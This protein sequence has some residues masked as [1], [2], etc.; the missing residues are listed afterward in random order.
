VGFACLTALDRLAG[1][2]I[3]AHAA[4]RPD[5]AGSSP[6]AV[7]FRGE[8]HDVDLGRPLGHEPGFE[9]PAVILSADAVNNG[10]R[11]IVL[12]VPIGTTGYG[13]RSHVELE[14]GTSGLTR[15]SY[16]RCDQ[17]RVVST[18]R[19]LRRRGVLTLDELT[20]VEQAVRFI[21]DL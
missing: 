2:P 18:E 16:A 20:S 15:T 3:E 5:E 1:A 17:L 8:V 6:D 12:V 10:P 13:L 9:R 14:P 7:I 19:L 21:L 11:G 4:R